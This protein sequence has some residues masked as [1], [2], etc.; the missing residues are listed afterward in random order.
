MLCKII[1]MYKMHLPQI[2]KQQHLCVETILVFVD[3]GYMCK[4]IRNVNKQCC[5]IGK[6]NLRPLR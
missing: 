5:H 1:E 3:L 6:D 4:F 2:F